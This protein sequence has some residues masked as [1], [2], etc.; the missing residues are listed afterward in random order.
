[1][2]DVLRITVDSTRC[3]GHGRCYDLFPELFEPDDEAFGLV[4]RPDVDAD[5][6]LAE[7]ARRAELGCPERAI[8]VTAG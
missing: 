7:Q 3:E 2:T 1:M 4:K 8:S 6:P 5:S